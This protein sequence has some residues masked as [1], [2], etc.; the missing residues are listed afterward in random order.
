MIGR[1]TERSCLPEDNCVSK[2]AKPRALYDAIQ[3]H[4]NR[5]STNVLLLRKVNAAL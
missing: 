4:R 2:R 1:A 3:H 5:Q